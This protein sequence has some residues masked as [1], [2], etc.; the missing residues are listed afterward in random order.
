MIALYMN[1]SAM[2]LPAFLANGTPQS[3]YHK[4]NNARLSAI[5]AEWTGNR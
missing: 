5:D 2:D 3:G 1:I 4:A